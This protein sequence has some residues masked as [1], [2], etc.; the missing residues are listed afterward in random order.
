MEN[1]SRDGNTSPPELSPEK[2]VCRSRS[3]LELDKEQQIGSR[4]GKE[5]IKAVHCHPTYLTYMQSTSCEMMGCIKHKLES[6]LLGEISIT[7]DMQMIPSWWQKTRRNW[8]ACWW[9]WKKR[10]KKLAW[11]STLKKRRSWHLV[12][13]LHGK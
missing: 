6:R 11:T 1:S 7:S 13:S 10:V 12:P 4:S 2:S 5:H 9:K 8:T 3:K